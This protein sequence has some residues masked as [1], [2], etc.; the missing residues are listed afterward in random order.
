[1]EIGLTI[2]ALI[3]VAVVFYFIGRLIAEL[4][5]QSRIKAIRKDS[6]ERSRAVVGGR[7]SE[8]LAPYLPD[9]PYLPT[10]AKFL[11][12]PVDLIVFE[13]LGSRIESVV[14]VEVKS[15]KASLSKQERELKKT[16]GEGK[17]RFETYRV[18]ER[19]TE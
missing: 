18:P 16:I 14:F 15:G 6:A 19:L 5:F 3:A 4:S 9:F 11:G 17:V 12:Q 10:E 1:M 2:L 7:F 8:Q 13:G